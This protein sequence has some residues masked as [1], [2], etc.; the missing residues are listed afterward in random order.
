MRHP[1]KFMQAVTM[2]A[3]NKRGGEPEEE[4]AGCPIIPT[5]YSILAPK[6]SYAA[7]ST[8]N[9]GSNFRQDLICS[10]QI[11]AFPIHLEPNCGHIRSIVVP[12]H[13]PL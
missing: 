8:S 1:K 10:R 5:D 2:L 9:Y 4:R 12:S 7:F 11:H 3:E 6:D 13:P